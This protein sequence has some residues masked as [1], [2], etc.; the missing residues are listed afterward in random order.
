[1]SKYVQLEIPF[2][3]EEFRPIE[4]YENLYQVS[5]YGRVYSL[6]SKKFLKSK[7]D[8]DGYLI[9][10]LSKDGE[11]KFYSIHRI[12]ATTFIENPSNLPQVNHRDENPS[13]NHLSNLE[14]CDA[15]YNNNYGTRTQRAI[16]K[17]K[18]NQ[19]WIASIRKHLKAIH[20]KKSK[21]VL[22]FTKQGEFVAEYHSAHEAERQTKIHN[23]HISS[24]CL[25]KK[26]HKSA[27]GYVWRFK[28]VS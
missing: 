6:I 21:T 14:W 27:R 17:R 23:S 1:M 3:F 28:S 8:K 15:K 20:E 22:Q 18:T 5:S 10:G 19:N 11:R 12:V 16:S 25:D 24:C 4:G 13:N 26:Y 9:V 2:D 7:K